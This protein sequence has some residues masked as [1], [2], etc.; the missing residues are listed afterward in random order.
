MGSYY[1]C[2]GLFVSWHP[3][4]EAAALEL[5]KTYKSYPVIAAKLREKFPYK[6]FDGDAV[7]KWFVYNGHAFVKLDAVPQEY[8]WG[9]TSKN[10]DMLWRKWVLCATAW[11]I[12]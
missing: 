1:F 11:T 12:T 6:F 2:G 5:A 9:S 8:G 7:R 10:L 3:D 4:W